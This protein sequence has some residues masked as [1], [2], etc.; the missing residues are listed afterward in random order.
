MLV[1]SICVF[2]VFVAPAIIE[3]TGAEIVGVEVSLIFC[4][5]I[6]LLGVV[7]TVIDGLLLVVDVIVALTVFDDGDFVFVDIEVTVV[8]PLPVSSLE[9]VLVA[10]VLLFSLVVLEGVVCETADA[11]EFVV[12]GDMAVVAVLVVGDCVFVLFVVALVLS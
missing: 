5:V 2:V 8:L 10:V 11:A 9:V 6:F 4:I 7:E 1:V 12:L 3:L